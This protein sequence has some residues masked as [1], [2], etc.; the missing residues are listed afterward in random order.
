MRFR[1]VKFA[2]VQYAPNEEY[3]H[4]IRLGQ[5]ITLSRARGRNIKIIVELA[6]GQHWTGDIS[7][8]V[9]PVYSLARGAARFGGPVG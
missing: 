1:S 6:V 4:T 7:T 8:R 5:R 9:Q 2:A 3:S